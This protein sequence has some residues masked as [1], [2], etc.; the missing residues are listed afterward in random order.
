MEIVMNSRKL[1]P[2]N[3]TL[4]RDSPLMLTDKNIPPGKYSTSIFITLI[5]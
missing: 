1:N 3:H 5:F 4:F 2:F